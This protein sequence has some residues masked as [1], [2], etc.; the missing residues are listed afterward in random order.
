MENGPKKAIAPT[1]QCEEPSATCEIAVLGYR[2]VMS[3]TAHEP[4]LI[5]AEPQC[6]S[7]AETIVA[8]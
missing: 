7:T 5:A 8:A 3:R 6:H 2:R 1:A 4:L